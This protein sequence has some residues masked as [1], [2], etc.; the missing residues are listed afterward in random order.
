MLSV[1]AFLEYHF[2]QK[3]SYGNMRAVEFIPQVLTQ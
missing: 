3:T 2:K 1:H